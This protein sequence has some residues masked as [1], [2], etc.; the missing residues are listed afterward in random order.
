M[1]AAGWLVL[2]P[3]GGGV[4]RGGWGRHCTGVRTAGRRS[5]PHQPRVSS[6]LP[7]DLQPHCPVIK[8][9]SG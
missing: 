3:A 9:E 6:R 1:L 8:Q 4:E 2:C 5:A 7:D